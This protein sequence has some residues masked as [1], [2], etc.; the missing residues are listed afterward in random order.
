MQE[1]NDLLKDIMKN[2]EV[3]KEKFKE[4]RARKLKAI[5]NS[6]MDVGVDNIR[7]L[8][9]RNEMI[10]FIDQC[11]SCVNCKNSDECESSS[12]KHYPRIEYEQGA[13]GLVYYPCGKTRGKVDANIDIQ[14]YNDYFKNDKRNKLLELM[15]LGDG[16]YI[17]GDGGRGK[18]YTMAYVCNEFNKKGQSIFFHLASYIEKTYIDFNTRNEL[19]EKMLSYDIVVIDDFGGHSMNKLAVRGLWETIIKQRL[20]SNKPTYFTS[21]YD[22]EHVIEQIAKVSYD[23]ILAG[24]LRDR[25]NMHPVLEFHDKNYRK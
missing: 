15:M 12:L 10:T 22:L 4:E 16:G 11:Y 14:K 2:V 6:S 25:I 5:Q 3:N 18:T 20:D 17:W 13:Y 21:N 24:V 8:T 23:Q 7:N 9:D 19:L 1:K